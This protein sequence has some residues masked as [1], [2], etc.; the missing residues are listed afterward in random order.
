MTKENLKNVLTA[1]RNMIKRSRVAYK[2][3][4]GTED[5]IEKTVLISGKL[6]ADGES[7]NAKDAFKGFAEGETY[8]VTVGDATVDATAQYGTGSFSGCIV[9]GSSN[10]M[11]SNEIPGWMICVYNENLL[12]YGAGEW[13]GKSVEVFTERTVKVDRWDVKKLAYELLP[14]RLL[15]ALS[16]VANTAHEA[17]TAANAAQSTANAAASVANGIV[18]AASSQG[19]ANT[20][21][22]TDIGDIGGLGVTKK[23]TAKG[24]NI[25]VNSFVEVTASTFGT[26]RMRWDGHSAAAKFPGSG[27]T[28]YLDYQVGTDMYTLSTV[29]SILLTI[30]KMEYTEVPL[31]PSGTIALPYLQFPHILLYSGSG[32]GKLFEIT[33]DDAGTL[34][35]TEVTDT[36]T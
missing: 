16:A 32:T 20:K 29:K 30:E 18:M 1:V 8:K 22:I 7:V 35:A 14:D 24:L 4:I 27:P 9:I 13:V 12:G 17:L 26:V 15:S 36:T 34:S 3:Y 5:V 28:I 10:V 19:A 21:T 2:D 31:S 6:S 11:P 33:V 25:Q 23:Y